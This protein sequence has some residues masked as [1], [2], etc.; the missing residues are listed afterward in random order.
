[1]KT[2]RLLVICIYVFAMLFASQAWATDLPRVLIVGEDADQDTIRRD[3]RVFKRVL[4]GIANTMI[5]KGFDVKDETAITLETHTQGRTRRNDAELIEIAKDTG[6]DVLCIFSIYPNAHSRATS[7]KVTTR[8]EGRLLSVNDGSRLGNFEHEPQRE[9]LVPKP[10]SRDD[11]IE[12]VGKL[13]KIIGEE[14]GDYLANRLENY[15]SQPGGGRLQEWTLI[16]DGFTLDEMA[17]MEKVLAIFTGYD[18]H[19]VKSNAVKTG[20]HHEYW[21][22]SSIN[23]AKMEQNLN[24]LLKKF[25]HDGRVYMS[26]LEVKVTKAPKPVQRRT[27]KDS[28]W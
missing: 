9:Q 1:M 21:Y 4:N 10:Y 3:T 14:V 5:N 25:N 18:S 19:R 2:Q 27:P 15:E 23:S 7:L 12:A 6:I 16:F 22:R 28:E 13:A 17:E 11:I 20:L 26:G 24:K 8:I